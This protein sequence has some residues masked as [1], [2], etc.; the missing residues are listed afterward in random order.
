MRAATREHGLS[1]PGRL[2]GL[3]GHW[4]ARWRGWQ[5]GAA[6]GWRAPPIVPKIIQMHKTHTPPIVQKG[7]DMSQ[8]MET[9]GKVK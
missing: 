6:H 9:G 8:R 1:P 2:A 7:K 4:G 3:G 5:G